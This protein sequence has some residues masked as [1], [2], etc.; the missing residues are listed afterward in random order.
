M[1]RGK[2]P[3]LVVIGLNASDVTHLQ[4]GGFI[5]LSGKDV[6]LPEDVLLIAAPTDPDLLK[7]ISAGIGPDTEVKIKPRET[8]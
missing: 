3:G 4:N 5:Q 8:R 1:I 7:K 6:D 2:Q